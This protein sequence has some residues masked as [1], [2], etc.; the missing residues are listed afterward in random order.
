VKQPR[1]RF[2]WL[3]P[4]RPIFIAPSYDPSDS[5][6]VTRW[7]ILY[8]WAHDDDL[9]DFFEN[10]SNFSAQGMTWVIGMAVSNANIN[11][12]AIIAF[13]F[14]GA[15]PSTTD[16]TTWYVQYGSLEDLPGGNAAGASQVQAGWLATWTMLDTLITTVV[17]PK[18]AAL[19]PLPANSFPA[20]GN[21]VINYYDDTWI[22]RVTYP[23]NVSTLTTCSKED[24]WWSV[25]GVTI[26]QWGTNSTDMF[27]NH[28]PTYSTDPN[29]N[30]YPDGWDIAENSGAFF[31]ILHAFVAILGVVLSATGVGAVIT[32]FVLAVA[33]IVIDF[34]Q[35][36]VDQLN[37]G[38]PAGAFTNIAQAILS[39]GSAEMASFASSAPALSK[40]GIS[41]LSQLGTTL[42]QI[43]TVLHGTTT[44][45]TFTESV[46]TLEQQ[47]MG[48]GPMTTA[49]FDAV[50][51]LLS[52]DGSIDS[53]AAALAQQ[54]WDTSQYATD[55]DVLGVGSIYE[56]VFPGGSAALWKMG[57]QL[58]TLARTQAAL[59]GVTSSP[60]QTLRGATDLQFALTPMQ[61]LMGYVTG[62]LAPRYN[63]PTM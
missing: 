4:P 40:L 18:R 46:S 49:H 54:G 8:D 21:V 24:Q 33:T 29:A 25:A 45:L 7:K 51:A 47:A 9:K 16:I 1:S 35:A 6:T 14:L 19:G 57:A 26:E 11:S 43:G 23:G 15:T 63:I 41:A 2:G 60:Y 59:G 34:L 56:Q 38:S 28:S 62:F 52:T 17:I 13:Y 48:Y 53:P 5:D 22:K 37:G 30:W 42:N 50:L 39:V 61:D 20:S 32:A 58:G 27:G 55:S 12:D 31:D 44:E 36:A 10:K 3:P